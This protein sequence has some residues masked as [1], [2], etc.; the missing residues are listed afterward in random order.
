[1]MRGKKN[2]L[3]AL[4]YVFFSNK[5][6]GSDVDPCSAA[7]GIVLWM[8]DGAACDSR[9]LVSEYALD[10]G[11]YRRASGDEGFVCC[12]DDYDPNVANENTIICEEVLSAL[13]LADVER[14]WPSETTL[15]ETSAGSYHHEASFLER[16]NI[17]WSGNV[18]SVDT[19][20]QYEG[21]SIVLDFSFDVSW[22]A[23]ENVSDVTAIMYG[24][25]GAVLIVYSSAI[26]LAKGTSLI[27]NRCD[28]KG[29]TTF[30]KV[31]DWS[32][33]IYPCN[34][35]SCI[36]IK[37]TKFVA[38]H[39]YGSN[40]GWLTV[41]SELSVLRVKGY[42]TF[43]SKYAVVAAGGVP[44]PVTCLVPIFINAILFLSSI[45]EGGEAVLIARS[46]TSL[47][48]QDEESYNNL[49][50]GRFIG[51]E[52][53]VPGNAVVSVTVVAANG[54]TVFEAIDAA[55]RRALT[56]TGAT[57]LDWQ[58]SNESA[59]NIGGGPV[60]K[61]I[62]DPLETE[63]NVLRGQAYNDDFGMFFAEILV[64]HVLVLR[65]VRQLLISSVICFGIH[66]LGMDLKMTF[67]L[68]PTKSVNAYDIEALHII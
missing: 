17:S 34:Q 2:V 25:D 31:L 54:D 19:R 11:D 14:K 21:G 57:S 24:G 37:V 53:E 65:V 51:N 27:S 26:V 9:D 5:V 66:M 68:P 45:A 3:C 13:C 8:P 36:F 63:N 52:V 48:P 12:I 41:C 1:M 33:L 55:V 18:F 30:S 43:I 50:K 44:I 61:T 67:V 4:I 6:G 20:Y 15:R 35:E 46:E 10:G 22:R 58:T 29:G 40:G 38:K 42:T 56:F 39:M 23:R 32:T 28:E 59:S 49:G 7:D 47:D 64:R 62:V 60:I 16:V